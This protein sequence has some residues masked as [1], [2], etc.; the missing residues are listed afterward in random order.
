MLHSAV[1]IACQFVITV[2]GADGTVS[3][4]EPPRPNSGHWGGMFLSRSR[5]KRCASGGSGDG[6]SV[7]SAVSTVT[8][9]ASD[10]YV[11][12][13]DFACGVGGVVSI[14]G[15]GFRLIAADDATNKW[16]EAQQLGL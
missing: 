13:E 2:Y 6:G 5:A 16:V 14:N 1:F 9:G 15:H 3:V 7:A 10:C 12:V 4:R 11:G 8:N